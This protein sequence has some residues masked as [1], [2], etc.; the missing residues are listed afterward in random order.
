M[1]DRGGGD[2]PTLPPEPTGEAL[3]LMAEL[4]EISEQIASVSLK[5]DLFYLWALLGVSPL[6]LPIFFGVSRF[7]VAALLVLSVLVS[8]LSLREGSR[9]SARLRELEKL[10][11][12][13]AGELEEHLQAQ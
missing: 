5:K 6:T 13:R 1:D 8:V 10:A 2:R 11:A 12:D 4:E 9:R 7:G 3:V